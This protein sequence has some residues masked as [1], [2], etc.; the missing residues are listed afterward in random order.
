MRRVEAD[1]LG[2]WLIKGNADHADLTG[3]FAREPR[4][5]RWCVQRSYRL[6]LMRAGQPVLFWAS[7]S[8]RRDIPYGIW[9]LGRLAGPPDRD[10][11]EGGWSVPLDLVISP[12]ADRVPREL[13]RADTE[14]AALEVFRQ[15]QAANPSFVTRREFAAI[16]RH[17][18][19]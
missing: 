4:V 9:G 14:L 18:A 17:L 6:E 7:G 2:A 3:R 16:A 5:T 19:V 1:N 15:P 10:A 11:A 12:E 13:L 8:R